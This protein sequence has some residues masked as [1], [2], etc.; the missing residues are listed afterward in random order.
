MLRKREAVVPRDVG[1]HGIG[2]PIDNSVRP[3]CS[4]RSMAGKN[5]GRTIYDTFSDEKRVI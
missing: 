3:A 5:S 1:Q 4:S 2:Q